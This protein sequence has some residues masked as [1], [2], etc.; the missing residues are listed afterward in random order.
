MYSLFS[1][2]SLFING[3]CTYNII[4]VMKDI[5]CQIGPLENKMI[6]FTKASKRIQ[7]IG[8]NITKELKDLYIENYDSDEKN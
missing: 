5:Q 4:A 3:C 1:K 7:H 8:I 2:S 6:P